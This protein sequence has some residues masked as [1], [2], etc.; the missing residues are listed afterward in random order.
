MFGA[1]N[2][3]FHIVHY[4]VCRC[5]SSGR[6]ETNHIACSRVCHCIRNAVVIVFAGANTGCAVE[7]HHHRRQWVGGRPLL[8][9]VL[10]HH[11][12]ARRNRKERVDSGGRC[13]PEQVTVAHTDIHTSMTMTGHVLG[14]Q[15]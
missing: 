4:L 2:N 6:R 1:M 14:P 12:D 15:K 5:Q 7:A 13:N 8:L 3:I 11:S 9:H 10:Q